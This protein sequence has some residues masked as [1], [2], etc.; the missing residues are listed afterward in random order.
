MNY[1]SQRIMF[2]SV[3]ENSGQSDFSTVKLFLQQGKKFILTEEKQ[4]KY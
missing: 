4:K 3:T 2:T 1:P